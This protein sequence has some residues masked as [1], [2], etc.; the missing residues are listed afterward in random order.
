MTYNAWTHIMQRTFENDGVVLYINGVAV[1]RF[2]P[3]MK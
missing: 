3:I 2:K 1:D